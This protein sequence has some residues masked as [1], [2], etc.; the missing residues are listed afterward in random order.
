MA[1]TA[2][3][4][5]LPSAPSVLSPAIRRDMIDEDDYVETYLDEIGEYDWNA[6]K[7]AAG[8]SAAAL[9][10]STDEFNAAYEFL[11]ARADAE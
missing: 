1:D 6:V 8:Q 9:D 3:P 11:C 4:K 7:A 2:Q 5:R 10:P